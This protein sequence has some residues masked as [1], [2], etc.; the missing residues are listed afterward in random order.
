MVK[1]IPKEPESGSLINN[2][3]ELE[4]ANCKC[5]CTQPPPIPACT[6]P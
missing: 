5:T 4:F 2:P 3:V 1:D 6:T